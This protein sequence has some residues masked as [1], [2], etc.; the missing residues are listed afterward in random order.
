MRTNL[1]KIQTQSSTDPRFEVREDSR[2]LAEAEVAAPSHDVRLSGGGR[3]FAEL[4]EIDQ[5]E[6]ISNSTRRTKEF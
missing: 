4:V 3:A 2:G 5:I 6:R 1:S